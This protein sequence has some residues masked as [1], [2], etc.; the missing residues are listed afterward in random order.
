MEAYRTDIKISLCCD[1]QYLLQDFSDMLFLDDFAIRGKMIN[2]E[3]DSKH[4]P[5]QS[6]KIKHYSEVFSQHNDPEGTIYRCVE[7]INDLILEN[8]KFC[9]NSNVLMTYYLIGNN[10]KDREEQII[11]SNIL[12]Y[13]SS[14]KFNEKEEGYQYLISKVKNSELKYLIIIIDSLTPIE[15]ISKTIDPI[16]KQMN[17]RIFL[18]YMSIHGSYL[19]RKIIYND[20]FNLLESD[21][22]YLSEY[23]NI[24]ITTFN[25][26]LENKDKILNEVGYPKFKKCI[27]EILIPEY[28]NILLFNFEIGISNS[29]EI[30]EQDPEKCIENLIPFYNNALRMKRAFKDPSC[31]E[32]FH[33]VVRSII[34]TLSKYPSFEVYLSQ[35]D[36]IFK[37]DKTITEIINDVKIKD[38]CERID[39]ASELIETGTF[40]NQIMLPG[41]INSIFTKICNLSCSQEQERLFIDTSL[42]SAQVM[43]LYLGKIPILL[44]KNMYSE[45]IYNIFFSVSFTKNLITMFQANNLNDKL[46]EIVLI[47]LMLVEKCIENKDNLKNEHKMDV[48][49]NYCQNLKYYLSKIYIKK[50]DY[51]IHNIIDECLLFLIKLDRPNL[52]NIRMKENDIIKYGPDTDVIELEKYIFEEIKSEKENENENETIFDDSDYDFYKSNDSDKYMEI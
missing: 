40:P 34:S 21:L 12:I 32:I 5:T 50:I 22:K 51:L 41:T 1:E 16:Q 2:F 47:K 52:R 44:K 10:F 36:A 8:D 37:H 48:L 24:P 27:R 38:I 26:I 28:M 49:A 31:I 15:E 23:A 4:C 18:I 19:A 3:I 13:I 9:I 11:R 29:L 20:K 14:S 25:D 45:I 42:L 6:A 43:D 17:E 7:R 33:D 39:K 46:L 35:L 30:L